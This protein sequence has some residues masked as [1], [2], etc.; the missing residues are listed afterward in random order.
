[1]Q[2]TVTFGRMNILFA[3]NR[4]F[5]DSSFETKLP[6]RLYEYHFRSFSPKK[7]RNANYVIVSCT[8]I[9]RHQFTKKR[10]EIIVEGRANEVRFSYAGQ[11][12]SI[13]SERP[14]RACIKLITHDVTYSSVHTCD[15][16]S[17]YVTINDKYMCVRACACVR[18]CLCI[19][20]LYSSFWNF[21]K[22]LLSV[23]NKINIRNET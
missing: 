11:Q 5:P 13:L 21:S 7:S 15:L 6:P 9:G 16:L 10:N 3:D 2:P 23:R 12:R 22:K 17:V 18:V 20:R 14:R 19:V 4:L 1:M 8:L